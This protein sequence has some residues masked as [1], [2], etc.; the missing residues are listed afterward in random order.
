MR[1]FAESCL[2]TSSKGRVWIRFRFPACHGVWQLPSEGMKNRKLL[3]GDVSSVLLAAGVQHHWLE[4]VT[5]S[6]P[7]PMPH[8]LRINCFMHTGQLGLL[9]IAAIKFACHGKSY[10]GWIFE[11]LQGFKS[12]RSI[13]KRPT[14]KRI[15]SGI[16]LAPVAYKTKSKDDFRP[17]NNSEMV[18]EDTRR[19]SKV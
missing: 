16:I 6:W 19:D 17:E 18:V 10:P 5:Q 11:V 15:G 3:Q 13:D 8:T 14:R 1:K 4:G 7:Y 12:E 9:R 2:E